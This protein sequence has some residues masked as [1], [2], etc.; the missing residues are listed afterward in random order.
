[1]ANW[2]PGRLLL[3]YRQALAA[4]SQATAV[5]SSATGQPARKDRSAALTCWPWPGWPGQVR[6]S[7]GTGRADAAALD[8]DRHWFVITAWP[9]A[10]GVNPLRCGV[11][12][13]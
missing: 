2:P 3:L 10:V 12:R 13:T 11:S 1:M 7:V 8:P 9:P 5:T 6:S 4:S